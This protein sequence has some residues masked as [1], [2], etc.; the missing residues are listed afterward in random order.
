M[1]AHH[2]EL[3]EDG[4]HAA[5]T[6]AEMACWEAAAGNRPAAGPAPARRC[7]PATGNRWR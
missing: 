4:R 5:R 3:R 2:P 6:L 1:S 7:G